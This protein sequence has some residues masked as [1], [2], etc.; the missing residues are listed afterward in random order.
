MDKEEADE[1]DV[2]FF[3]ERLDL[4]ANRLSLDALFRAENIANEPIDGP[5]WLPAESADEI[6]PAGSRG[7]PEC[8]TGDFFFFSFF[9]RKQVESAGKKGKRSDANYGVLR[10][11]ENLKR[12]H[13]LFVV[14]TLK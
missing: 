1:T 9:L 12:M 5:C 13:N 8:V 6:A 7:G 2:V 3:F 11:A 14:E 4:S 10:R